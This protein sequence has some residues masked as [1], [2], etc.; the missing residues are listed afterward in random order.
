ALDYV[1]ALGMPRVEA[2]NLALR[3]RLFEALARVPRIRVVSPPPGPLASPLVTWA[4]PDEVESRA[5]QLRMLEKHQGMLKMVPKEWLNGN[6]ASCHLFN[7]DRDADRLIDA[8]H[9][10][11]G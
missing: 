7:T 2:H 3:N 9:A 4:L 8:L 11:L 10:E 5:F 6:R 1:S